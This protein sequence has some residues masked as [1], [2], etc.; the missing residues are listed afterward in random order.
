MREDLI[1][2]LTMLSEGKLNVEKS[3]ELIDVMY[4]KEEKAIQIVEKNYDKRMLKIKVD[5]SDGDKV[6]VN[7]PI[8][9]ITSVLKATGKLPIKNVDMEGIDFEVLIETIIAA[10]DNEMIGEIVTVDSSDGDVVRVVIE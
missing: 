4:K 2:I 3:A 1:K 6:N 8:A 5:S 10:L 9:V 7:L